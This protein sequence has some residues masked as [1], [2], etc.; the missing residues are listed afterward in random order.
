MAP[1]EDDPA[2][3]L[4]CSRVSLLLPSFHRATFVPFL[5]QQLESTSRI[6]CV[7]DHYFDCSIKAYADLSF[8]TTKLPICGVTFEHGCKQDQI[9]SQQVS[10]IG[11]PEHKLQ[12][13]D[14]AYYLSCSRVLL[15]LPSFHSGQS[16]PFP[17]TCCPPTHSISLF[18][19]GSGSLFG[20]LLSI[21]VP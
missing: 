10:S 19:M 5:L 20:L 1:E 9:V 17:C 6:D 16:P 4:S 18:N 21:A 12:E 13:D 3:Y 7:W 8:W 14:S 11:I 15:L 2:Y